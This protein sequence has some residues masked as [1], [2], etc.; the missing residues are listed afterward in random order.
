MCY[1][2][3][4]G[5]ELRRAGDWGTLSASGYSASEGQDSHGEDGVTAATRNFRG[6]S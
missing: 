1:M 2:S 4:S 3:C 5:P 6:S